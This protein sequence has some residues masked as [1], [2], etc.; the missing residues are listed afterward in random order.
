MDW[1]IA[2]N[3]EHY[4]IFPTEIA[5]MTQHSDIII[6][7]IKLKKLMVPFEENFV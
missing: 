5:L 2:T 7:S 1:C 4:F 3:L 6:W